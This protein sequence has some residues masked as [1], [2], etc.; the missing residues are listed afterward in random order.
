MTLATPI[1][2][3]RGRFLDIQ[4]TV[5]QATEIADQVR[6]IEDGVLITEQGKIRWFG[7]WDAAQ[8]HLPTDVEI[9]HY[10]DQ[11][12]IPGMIDTHIH[13]PQTEMVGAYGEQ[14]LSWLNTYTFPTEIQ[15]KDQ[16]YAEEIA[17]FFVQELLK[18]GTTTA[19]VFCTVHPESV[20]ALFEAA[21]QYQM[22]LIAG[23][24]MMDRHAPEALCDTAESAYDDSK[25]LIEKWHGQGRALYAITPRFA[26]TST[27]EQLEKAGQLKAEYPDVY[28]HTHLSEN[29][30]EIAWVK[31]LFP[32]QKGYLDVY[33]HYG[34]T[35]QRSVFAHCV[36]LEDA[37][38][39][40]MHETDSAIAFCPTSN[41]FL[42]SGLFPLKKTWEQQVKVG[43]GTD[44]GAGTSFS[45]LQTVNEA[46]K[47]QQLQGDKLS[48]FESLYHATLGGAKALDLD[49]KLGNFNIGKEADF[50]VL[51]LQATALQQLRQSRSK[52]IDDSLF[53][54]FTMGDD[55][56]IEATYIYGQKAYSAN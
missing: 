29:K 49:D 28:V 31:D 35:G 51:N 25:A 24:V 1:T 20:N 44:I 19:L 18:N 10:P 11:L 34:L 14:L 32:A 4:K 46:Y 48:A 23:K 17:K 27:P 38:W 56:N 33:H 13:F 22:R 8:D 7:T 41:L 50:V 5:S 26:P 54:L 12:I 52:S 43:L 40:C 2:V 15:F 30:D 39:Q 53:A 36:H 9:Q 16:A 21:E 45:L 47:V 6:Y 3:I 55:R 42:G 37:E